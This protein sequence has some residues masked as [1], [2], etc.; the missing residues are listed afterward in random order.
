MCQLDEKQPKGEYVFC[1]VSDQSKNI[2]EC[3]ANGVQVGAIC[4][5]HFRYN[6][7][8]EFQGNKK[9]ITNWPFSATTVGNLGILLLYV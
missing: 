2:L 9:E 1:P 8:V 4:T 7:I 3:A 6:V 5:I